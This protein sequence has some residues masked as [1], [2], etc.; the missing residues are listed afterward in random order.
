MSE[1]KQTKLKM[2]PTVEIQKELEQLYHKNKLLPRLRREFNLIPEIP[3]KCEELGFPEGFGIDLLCHMV[4]QKRAKVSTLVGLLWKYFNKDGL[5]TQQAMQQCAEALLVAAHNN[6]VNYDK[7][8]ELFI[9]RI[10]LPADVHEDLERYQYPLPL[11]VRP[12]HVGHNRETGYYTDN[13]SM[14]L[15]KGNHHDD[16]ICLNH[17]NRVNRTAL[18]IDVNTAAFIKNSWSNL[19]SPKPGESARQ[20]QQRKRAFYK[21]DVA[22]RD[23]MAGILMYDN[24]FYIAHKYDKRGR[25]YCMGYHINPQG[26]AWNKA[27]VNFANQEVPTK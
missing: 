23:I 2:K 10:D 8:T 27:V 22:T 5:S 9:I 12:R 15:K 19:N 16:D 26:N 7:F 25:T 21:Y 18:T 17:I 11:L 6:F 20:F 14:I 4:I 24:K 13:S 1:P 3:A